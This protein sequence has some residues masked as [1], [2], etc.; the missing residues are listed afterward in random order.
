MA[1]RNILFLCTGNSARSILAEAIANKLGKGRFRA[2]SAGSHP[3]GRVNP[4]AI[5]LLIDLGYE[6]ARFRSK[7]W[8]EFSRPGAPALDI[9]ITVCDSAARDACPIWPGHPM[10]AHW[11][12]PDPAAVTGR[13]SRAAFVETYE[14]LELRIQALV[15][16]PIEDLAPDEL[17]RRMRAIG[18]YGAM[19]PIAL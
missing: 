11:G 17:R 19:A 18:H 16:L 14:I 15:G 9:V 4:D 10:T 8:M 12:M 6:T 1:V 5:E 3:T 13:R 2:F 7:S